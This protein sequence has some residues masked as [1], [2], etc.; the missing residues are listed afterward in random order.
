MKRD[1]LNVKEE[2]FDTTLEDG[3]GNEPPQDVLKAMYEAASYSGKSMRKRSIHKAKNKAARK[4]GKKEKIDKDFQARKSKTQELQQLLNNGGNFSMNDKVSRETNRNNVVGEMPKFAKFNINSLTEGRTNFVKQRPSI[5]CCKEVGFMKP[6]VDLL[7]AEYQALAGNVRSFDKDTIPTEDEYKQ[8][9]NTYSAVAISRIV[10]SNWKVEVVTKEAVGK[11]AAKVENKT[12]NYKEVKDHFR[13]PWLLAH[14]VNQFGRYENNDLG[15]TVD[16]IW[17]D[18]SELGFIA[19]ADIARVAQKVAKLYGLNG[20]TSLP[21]L[22]AEQAS[23]PEVMTSHMEECK[24]DG[25]TYTQ[26]RQFF[27]HVNIGNMLVTSRVYFGELKPV[28]EMSETATEAEK[29]EA[30]NEMKVK[31]RDRYLAAY[32][33]AF[34]VGYF[35]ERNR[36]MILDEMRDM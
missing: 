12:L 8:Y 23:N 24:V 1:D 7:K 33:C 31:L 35:L 13:Q 18:F 10:K 6:Q 30:I 25:D 5:R 15:I 9:C 22:Q 34:D 32:I 36:S 4:Q 17:S 16:P 14:A 27:R 28:V 21:G 3:I 26:I 2:S 19:P 20:I 29:E 11:G